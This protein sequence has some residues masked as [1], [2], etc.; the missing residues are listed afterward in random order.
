MIEISSNVLVPKLLDK[1]N[2]YTNN[3]RR[4]IK[5]DGIFNELDTNA[6]TNFKKFIKL[7]D[8]RYKSVKSGATINSVLRQ[9]KPEYTELSNDIL[10]N[11]SYNNDDLEEEAKK[12][13]KKS[14]KKDNEN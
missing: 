13:L 14:N 6:N 1:I 8:E 10:N 3:L 9:Q 5:V 12:L 11:K 7:S 4:R 2:N